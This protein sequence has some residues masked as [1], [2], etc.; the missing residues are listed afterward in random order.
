[1][2]SRAGSNPIGRRQFIGS[3]AAIGAAIGFGPTFWSRALAAPA[4]PGPGP[5]GAIDG[6]TPDANGLLLPP[7]FSSRVIART[8]EP[9][10]GTTYAWHTAPDGAATFA[11]PDGGWVLVSNAETIAA[12][13]GGV[14]AIRFDA[15]ANIT[16][17]YRILTGS[18]VNCAGGPTPWGTWL[19]CEE[20]D[21][22]DATAPAVPGFPFGPGVA[23]QVW[24]CDPL[25]VAL[26]VPLPAL[27]TFSH[28]AVAVDPITNRIYLTEDNGV[29]LLYRFTPATPNVG[30]R[31]DLTTG[32]LEVAVLAQPGA[33]LTTGSSVSWLP[34]P[35]PT[36][37]SAATRRQ[38]PGAT[39]FARG[40][41]M[42]FDSGIVYFTTTGDDRVWALDVAADHIEVIYDLA[43]TPTPPLEDPDNITVHPGSGDLFVAE[44]DGNLE[45]V[46][47]TAPE[48]GGTRTTTSFL[49]LTGQTGTEISGPCFDP[50]GTRLY[51][52]SQRG[53]DANRGITYEITGPFR[54]TGPVPVVAEAPLG[55][56]LPLAGAA[57][58]GGALVAMHRREA[59]PAVDPV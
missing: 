8:G 18:N 23:G 15:A 22:W 44:D 37:V 30:G 35:D 19:T 50:S 48:A 12:L 1:M 13:G 6:Q 43:T 42:W 36:S 53:I 56:L 58:V 28:E 4:I 21:L 10:A 17:A 25:G 9:V 39:T 46:L 3:A 38:V 40:E 47:I 33:V 24:E 52:S 16:G 5:Y 59:T 45:L 57:A 51:V 32:L 55:V 7:G 29:G 49:R 2:T 11:T 14:S 26:G 27:G 41:G 54:G 20:F 34:V 31:P